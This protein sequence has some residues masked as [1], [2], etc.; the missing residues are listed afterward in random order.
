MGTVNENFST[1][2]VATGCTAQQTSEMIGKR[3]A[4]QG[5]PPS[6]YLLYV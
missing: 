1:L 3:V 6:R 4:I 2:A 5:A